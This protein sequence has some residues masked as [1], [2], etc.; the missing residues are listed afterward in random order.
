MFHITINE[1]KISI[2]FVRAKALR[3]IAPAME[4]VSRLEKEEGAILSA[5]EMDKLVK[6]FCIFANDEITMDEIYTHYPSDRLLPD[7]FLAA[8]AVQRRVT[9][10]LRDFPT[11]AA[12]RPQMMENPAAETE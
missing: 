10:M 1:K 2:P 5:D 9:E 3:E 6:W 8:F 7:I 4:I 12:K 11:Q